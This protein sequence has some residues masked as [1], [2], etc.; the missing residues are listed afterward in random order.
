MESPEAQAQAAQMS[1]FMSVRRGT[2]GGALRLEQRADAEA[3]PLR[4]RARARARARPR[5][6]SQN[7]E[8]QKRMIAMQ[9]DPEMKEFFDAVKVR[10]RRR[11]RW[12]RNADLALSRA[13]FSVRARAQTGG[14]AALAKFWND[15]KMLIKI[16]QRLGGAAGPQ[17]APPPQAPQKPPEVTNLLEAC[18]WGDLE[19][20]EDFIAIGKGVNEADKEGRTALCAPQASC[21]LSRARTLTAPRRRHFAV[22]FG[23]A[24]VGLQIVKMLLEAGAKPDAVDSK[25]NTTLHYAVGCAPRGTACIAA[26]LFCVF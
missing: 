7:P 21:C 22:A 15:E 2:S 23:R 3:Q 20:A 4:S 26:C 1:A 16:S 5:S 13:P 9:D 19:A 10:R 17:A 11:R 12:A 8:V 6:R 24:E 18:R 14:P 25:K